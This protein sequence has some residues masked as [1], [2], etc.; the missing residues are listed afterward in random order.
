MVILLGEIA[1]DAKGWSFSSV[2]I[3]PQDTHMLTMVLEY[4]SQHKNP[5]FMSQFVG[6]RILYMEHLG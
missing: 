5:I 3:V 2:F 1:K 6:K 4:E